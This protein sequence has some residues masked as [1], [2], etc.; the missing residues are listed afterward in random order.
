ML[1]WIYSYPLR[2]FF[3]GA[4][5][6]RDRLSKSKE[7]ERLSSDVIQYPYPPV[8]EERL[9]IHWP[10][11]LFAASPSPIIPII[12]F[13]ILSGKAALTSIDPSEGKEIRFAPA[14]RLYSVDLSIGTASLMLNCKIDSNE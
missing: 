1:D 10:L 5:L 13:S 11:I 9:P 7:N 14:S 6:E 12:E 3:F 8:K 4:I 2:L